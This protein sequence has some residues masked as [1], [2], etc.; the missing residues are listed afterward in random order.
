MVA[1]QIF[2]KPS[3]RKLGEGESNL[4]IIFFKWV[5][6]TTN[7]FLVC[8]NLT[9]FVFV[10][11]PYRCPPKKRRCWSF[12]AIGISF[13]PW[14]MAVDTKRNTGGRNVEKKMKVKDVN[15]CYIFRNSGY[16]GYLIDIT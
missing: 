10:G 5:G 7:Q 6:S 15:L 4:T 11:R 16:I 13:P 1:T 12:D 2:F 8:R 14:L 9:T 3:P